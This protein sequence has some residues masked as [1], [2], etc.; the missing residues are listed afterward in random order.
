MKRF[1]YMSFGGGGTYGLMY[2]GMHRAMHTHISNI[3]D[4]SSE[5]FFEQIKGFAGISAGALAALAFLLN[6]SSE[7]LLEIYDEKQ[8]SAVGALDVA[9]LVQHYGL[10]RGEALQT[11]IRRVLACGGIS[12]NATFADLRRLLRRDFVCVATDVHT[13][14]AVYF[15]ANKTPNVRVAEAIYMSMTIPFLFVPRQHNDMYMIDGGM[16]VQ[17]PNAFPPEETLFVDID[18]S[19]LVRPVANLQEYCIAC[20]MTRQQN[21]WHHGYACL[22]LRIPNIV[23]KPFDFDISTATIDRFVSC[24]YAHTM[25]MLY[26]NLFSQLCEC[27]KVTLVCLQATGQPASESVD[28]P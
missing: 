18:W 22:T 20:L 15:S 8:F 25:C 9:Q 3:F 19:S 26:P 24:G 14:S 16:S 23:S 2:V 11:I 4:E 12:E 5:D 17:I 1:T 21:P 10:N 6:I 13:S 27:I 7:T 28:E